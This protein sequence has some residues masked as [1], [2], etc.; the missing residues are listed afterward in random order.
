MRLTI[1]AGEAGVSFQVF[2]KVDRKGRNMGSSREVQINRGCR[3]DVLEEFL[4]RRRVADKKEESKAISLSVFCPQYAAAVP[5]RN[6]D[7]PAANNTHI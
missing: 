4:K 2:Q 6:S 7:I 1:T 5:R 3:T